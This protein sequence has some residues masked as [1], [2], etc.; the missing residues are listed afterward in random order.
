MNPGIGIV[1]THW[2]QDKMA[3]IFADIF[4]CILLYEN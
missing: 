1:L 2:S 4:K 3:T